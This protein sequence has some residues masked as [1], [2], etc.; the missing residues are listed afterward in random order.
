MSNAYAIE[1]TEELINRQIALEEECLSL[2]QTRYNQGRLPWQAKSTA[3]PESQRM[4]GRHLIKEVL[5]KVTEAIV[6]W[7]D[8]IENRK[9]RGGN[10]LD[11]K[12][13]E[14][15]RETKPEAAAYSVLKTVLDLTAAQS[16]SD[17][18]SIQMVENRVSGQIQAQ[19]NYLR[20]RSQ[21]PNVKKWME[22]RLS[23][24]N[25]FAYNSFTLRSMAQYFGVPNVV[26][27]ED[28]KR[29]MGKLLL[30][31]VSNIGLITV[32]KEWIGI[33]KSQYVV[34]MSDQFQQWLTDKH[35]KFS[36]LFPVLLPMITPPTPWT[37]STGGGYL[38][39]VMPNCKLVKTP[40]V[41]YLEDLDSVE[42][43]VVYKALNAIQDTPW[44]I[45]RKVLEVMQYC[46]DH[47]IE[48]GKLPRIDP[49]PEP[50]KPEDIDTNEEARRRW[51]S[52]AH[53][54]HA[55]NAKTL[56][57]RVAAAQ[58]LWIAEKFVDEKA[59]WFPHCLDWRGRLYPI[60][61]MLTPQG[62]DVAKGLLQFAQGKPLGENGAYWLAVHIANVWGEDK[63]TMDDRVQWVLDHEDSILAIA[64][65]P[66]DYELKPGMLDWKEA[67]KPFQFLA[68]CLEWAGY[69]M[70][71]NDY[72][73]HLPI[74]MD[75]SCSGLQ[76]FSAMLRDPVGGKAVNLVP[77]DR[78]QDIYQAVADV[79]EGYV[80]KDAQEGSERAQKWA[81]KVNRKVCKTPTMTLPY[82]VTKF[83][84]QDQVQ[85]FL[86]E[87]H[88]EGE[89]WFTVEG[90][91]AK[92]Y[93]PFSAYMGGLIYQCVGEV[94]RAAPV[95]M[96]WLQD[97]SKVMSKA[98]LPLNWRSPAGFPVQQA[99][100]KQKQKRV[101]TVFG[102]TTYTLAYSEDTDTI[103]A[104]RQ[105][106]GVAP[107]F[108]H[109]LDASHLMLTVSYA[110]DAGIEDFAMI[111][112]SFGCHAC[113]TDVLNYLIRETFIQ[114]YSEDRLKEFRD[115][116]LKQLPEELRDEVPPLPEK[117]DLDLGSVRDSVYFFA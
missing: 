32:E 60:P 73:S 69:R 113:D 22:E 88:E 9:G 102:G 46:R 1:I 78:P 93:I 49:L 91:G 83:G 5:P 114:Q 109:S 82:G 4:P 111:H 55:I 79:V 17:R 106:S 10:H 2:G 21:K 14:L 115:I 28:Q 66:I 107:N 12:V 96:K 97:L 98:G 25:A 67:D 116:V 30:G 35:E 7:M 90:D 86:R 29:R 19:I 87:K 100:W 47:N 23:N 18:V 53:E 65:D 40:N 42:M 16:S 105:A 80:E 45:N 103:D 64:L 59:I 101:K 11:K 3:S 85:D 68:G 36:R 24:S 71:G 89:P 41:R 39:G 8:S 6:D 81:G 57:K 108:V 63:E 84:M 51:R 77:S 44:R 54:V 99:Y 74:A 76:H 33:N 56:G 75:G 70:T 112:D 110:L 52:E 15:L 72:V 95:A 104:R 27:T 117:G 58:K 94:V 62:D 20:I 43:P 61:N 13:C 37:S 31:I 38:S 34:R 50:T 92:A 26:I 48:V